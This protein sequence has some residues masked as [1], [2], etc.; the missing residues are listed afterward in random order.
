MNTLNRFKACLAAATFVALPILSNGCSSV[1]DAQG[2]VCCSEFKAGGAIDAKIG[3]SLEAQAAVQAVADF[4]GI[5]SAGIDD[6][7]AA[8]RGIATD[9]EADKAKGDAAEANTDKQAKMKAWCDLAVTTIGT[10]KGKAGG[11]LKL[12]LVPPVCSA[13]VSAKANCTAKCS[14][15]AACD[16]KANPPKCTGGSLEV[17]CKGGCTATGSAEVKCEGSCS[18]DCHGSCEATGGVECSGKCE[19]TC[20]AGGMAGG[21]GAQADGTCKGMCK[22]TCSASPPGVKCTGSCKGTCS[23]KCE[24]SATVSAKCDGKCDAD[25]EPLKCEGGKLEGGCMASAKCEGNCD[26]SVSAKA[27]CTP[28]SVSIELAGSADIQFA[29]KLKATLEANLPLIFQFKERLK[30]MA[31]LT[32]TITGSADVIVDI[33]AACIIQVGAAAVAAVSDVGASVT[34]TA[35]VV[36]SVGGS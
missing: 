1:T 28:P 12:V 29:G 13:S 16:F 25:F 3:G 5:A 36:G 14:G 9:L 27:E 30:A 20:T 17:A 6:I 21:N 32:G 19:G 33:K 7:T 22:G 4:S 23:A 10:I 26:A 34:A 31:T 11:T 8:C 35:S 15:T 24:G 18:A 2:A